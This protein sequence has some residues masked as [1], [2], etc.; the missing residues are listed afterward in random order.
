MCIAASDN[1]QQPHAAANDYQSPIES[2][3]AED[4]AI[5]KGGCDAARERKDAEY[6]QQ[7]RSADAAAA[8]ARWAFW[9]FLASTAGVIA[10]VITLIYTARATNA[11]QKSADAAD[12]AVRGSDAM[13]EHAQAASARELR[14]YVFVDGGGILDGN[15][16]TPKNRAFINKPG[17]ILGFKNYGKTPAY[18][19]AHW[20]D[21]NVVEPKYEHTLIIPNPITRVSQNSMGE[22]SIITT[23]PQ[24]QR[25]LTAQ[26]S[27][28]I[29]SGSHAIYIYGRIEYEDTFRKMRFTNFRLKYVGPYP[30]PKGHTLKFCVDGNEAD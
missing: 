5:D 11:A 20:V 4:A 27:T 14:A 17:A 15:T 3:F 29:A 19:V 1:G 10:V 23:N 24:L 18:K 13:L 30:P 28:G 9:Q 7:R 12:K 2:A 21:I 25:F 6:C 26:E 8:Q 22:G 16:T